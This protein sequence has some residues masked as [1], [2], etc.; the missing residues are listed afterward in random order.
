M[1]KAK[2]AR[3]YFDNNF[4]CAQSVLVTFADEFNISEDV[5]LRIA[6]AFGGGM[7]RQQLTCGAVSGAL[8]V[9]GLKYGKSINDSEEKKKL[10]YSKTVE[11]I[12]EFKKINGSICCKDLL[13]GLDMN[14]E[15]DFKKILSQNM[16]QIRCGKYVGDAATIVEKIIDVKNK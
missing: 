3:K 16:F 1:N 7:G 13:D 14:N 5:A 4:N 6:C 10:T 12:N 9:I 15:E 2:E 11:F 8:M